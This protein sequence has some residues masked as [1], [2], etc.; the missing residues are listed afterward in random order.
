[1]DAPVPLVEF[2]HHADT[3]GIRRP[4]GEAHATDAIDLDTVR[5]QHPVTLAQLAFAEQVQIL[6]R[7]V[8]R[9]LVGIENVVVGAA[10]VHAQA[11]GAGGFKGGAPFEH[12]GRVNALECN[13]SGIVQQIDTGGVRLINPDNPLRALTMQAEQAEWIVEAGLQQRFDRLVHLFHHYSCR[14]GRL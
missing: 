11:V 3:L 7:D 6:R 8:R 13:A 4:D 10:V 9:K 14:V 2:A 1:M 5:P 12:A